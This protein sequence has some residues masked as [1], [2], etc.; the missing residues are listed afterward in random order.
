MKI[1]HI[2]NTISERGGGIAAAVANIARSQKNLG[3]EISIWV[4][5]VNRKKLIADISEGPHGD[6]IDELKVLDLK[7][8]FNCLSI[9][10]LGRKSLLSQELDSFDVLHR[11]GLWTPISLISFLINP[12]L[13]NYFLSPHGLLNYEALKISK[14]KKQIF[15]FL[16]EKSTFKKSAALILS[17]EYEAEEILRNSWAIKKNISI[18]PNG[19]DDYFFEDEIAQNRLIKLNEDQSAIKLSLIH[20]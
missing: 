5:S 17:S 18:I 9:M 2:T 11:H 12:R 6:L 13:Q 14:L 10:F 7:D 3:H 4:F 16:I 15:S 20:I 8:L 1:A 19:V